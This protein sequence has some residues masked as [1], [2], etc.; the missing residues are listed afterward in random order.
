M[1]KPLTRGRPRR[2][3]AHAR[4]RAASAAPTTSQ[5]RQGGERT[6]SGCSCARWSA[7]TARPP[8]RR[9][10]ASSPGK[11]LGAN[12]IEFVN[13]I[14]DHLTEHGVMDAALLY[15][16][17]FTDLTP[18]GPDGLFTSAQVDELVA[19][20]DQVRSSAIAA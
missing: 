6:G 18:H 10:P 4:R 17:P 1:N 20:L 8:R 13:L 9:S 14:V 2:A 7:W 16:S 3:G 11:T 5:Q 19:T 12:Q 15:E